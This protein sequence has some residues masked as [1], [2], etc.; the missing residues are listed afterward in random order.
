[1]DKTIRVLA[2][3]TMLLQGESISSAAYCARMGCDRRTFD[4]DVAT[5]RN[6]LQ[7]YGEDRELCCDRCTGEYFFRERK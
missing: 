7:C 3:Y 1:M 5:V 2:F 6:F 4:R